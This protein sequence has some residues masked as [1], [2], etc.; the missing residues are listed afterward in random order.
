MSVTCGKRF[1][2]AEWSHRLASEATM[3]GG[4][5]WDTPLQLS[6][7]PSLQWRP[8][9]AALSSWGMLCVY[10]SGSVKCRGRSPPACPQICLRTLDPGLPQQF[11]SL[12]T[13]FFPYLIQVIYFTSLY[14]YKWKCTWIPRN[15]WF[16]WRR[17]FRKECQT[18]YIIIRRQKDWCSSFNIK[19]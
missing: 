9:S 2:G 11:E 15:N 7:D 17:S 19:S 14:T 12:R 13:K 6:L 8:L 3:L 10:L 4:F 18:R 16:F 1:W 5:A